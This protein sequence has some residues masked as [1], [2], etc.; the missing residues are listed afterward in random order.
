[1]TVSASAT[2]NVAVVGVQFKLD[3]VNLGAEDTTAPY[4]VSWNTAGSSGTHTLT[5]VARDAAGN[6]TTSAPVTITIGGGGGGATTVS[7]TTPADRAWIGGSVRIAATASS[8]GAPLASLKVWGNGGVVMQATCTGTACSI[9]D[10]WTT[11]AL[12]NSAYQVHA[13]ATDTAGASTISAPIVLNKNQTAPVVPSGVQSG[14]G[15]AD[16]TAPTVSITSPASGATLSGGTTVT[17]SATDNVGVV[18]VQFKL[19]GINLGTGDGG[20]PYSVV[21]DTSM[22]TAGTH[23]LTA[24]ARDAAGNTTT[25]APIT[26]TVAA[27]APPTDTTPPSVTITAP[28]TGAWTGN[29]IHVTATATDSVGVAT[30]K[31]YGNG[32]QF[33]P[34]VLCQGAASCT[35]DGWWSTGVLPSGQHTIVAVATDTTGNEASSSPVTINK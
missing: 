3:G 27:G 11:S 31:L 20:S 4:A 24:V 14:G 6:T 35:F 7:I 26:V 1:M 13:V 9:D 32:V 22:S 34:T 28:T 23:T 29:S 18:G 30:I 10:W 12:P 17:A 16:V 5:A 2:D 21:W 25:S 19:D 15:G 33:G 8:A